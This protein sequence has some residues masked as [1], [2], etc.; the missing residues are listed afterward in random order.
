MASH[1]LT[2]TLGSGSTGRAPSL[3]SRVKQSRRLAKLLFLASLRSTS[4]N[5]RH[6]AI[7][8]S[9][10]SGCSIRLNQPTNRV[11]APARNAIGQQE[12]ESSWS[13]SRAIAER[14]VMFL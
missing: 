11:S 10:T 13:V 4:Q 12:I 6:I 5:S 3:S 7:D 1:G 9:R 2:S 14:T 8:K